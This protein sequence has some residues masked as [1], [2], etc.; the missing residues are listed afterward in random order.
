MQDDRGGVG[1]KVGAWGIRGGGER[2]YRQWCELG[3]GGSTS[4]GGHP[5]PKL[6]YE[7]PFNSPTIACAAWDTLVWTTSRTSLRSTFP[8]QLATTPHRDFLISHDH[9]IPPACTSH[10]CLYFTLHY[11]NLTSTE[12]TGLMGRVYHYFNCCSRYCR[13]ARRRLL[14]GPV[15]SW[16]RPRARPARP[17]RRPR[18]RPLVAGSAAR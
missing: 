15:T 11:K 16:R 7:L 18:T 13:R 17:P 6:G 8:P 14:T 3:S 12:A 2:C 1:G 5:P 10:C 4:P 9:E